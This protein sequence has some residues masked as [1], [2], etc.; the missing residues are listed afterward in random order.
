MAKPPQESA[1]R[2]CLLSSHA[3][4]FSEFE[5]CLSRLG[6]DL[7]SHRINGN[8]TTATGD[9]SEVPDAS[10]YVIDWYSDSQATDVLLTRLVNEPARP[11]LVVLAEKF[12]EHTAFPML[13]RGVKGLLTYAEAAKQ[14]PRALGAVLA[15]GYWVPRALLSRFVDSILY[16]ERGP[17]RL[18][19]I[20]THISQREHQILNAL[21]E[22][23]SNKEIANQFNISE[24]TVKFHVSN[25]LAKYRVQ[26]R[27]DLILLCFQNRTTPAPVQ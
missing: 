25:L 15:G 21:V 1:L 16:E 14:L 12:D 27:A 4:F 9:F 7:V 23:R 10:A 18:P 26:R 19:A 6:F 20:S 17:R 5:A 2:V 8:L 11:Q 13:R 22:N 24:R 3:L